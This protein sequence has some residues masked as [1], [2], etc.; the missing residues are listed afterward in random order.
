MLY[1]LFI[2][3][4]CCFVSYEVA[5]VILFVISILMTFGLVFIQAHTR[6][7]LQHKLE[8]QIFWT[9][10]L[11]ISAIAT[12]Y[13]VYTA[14]ISILLITSIVCLI[15]DEYYPKDVQRVFKKHPYLFKIFSFIFVI[16]LLIL[17]YTLLTKWWQRWYIIVFLLL[18]YS[19]AIFFISIYPQINFR[20]IFGSHTLLAKVIFWVTVLGILIWSL[21]WLNIFW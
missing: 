15:I 18:I 12:Y 8:S 17:Y 1:P 21:Y 7:D 14:F 16:I 10:M 3:V 11:I 20:Q 6:D 9:I 19:T 2:F 4:L 13:F 5:F